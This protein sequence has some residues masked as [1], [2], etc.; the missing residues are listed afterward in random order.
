[1]K[2]AVR[3]AVRPYFRSP[4]TA[5]VRSLLTGGVRTR[6]LVTLAIAYGLISRFFPAAGRSRPT[7][8]PPEEIRLNAC[9][10]ARICGTGV[11]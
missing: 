6:S 10:P 5:P 2:S 4:P 11:R 7:S 8:V 9:G 1:V 3:F